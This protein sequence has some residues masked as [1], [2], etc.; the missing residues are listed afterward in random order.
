MPTHETTS[1][2]P[3]NAVAAIKET[4]RNIW[5]S[6]DCAAVANLTDSTQPDHLLRL[7]S[8]EPGQRIL[9]VA[10]GSGNVALRAAKAALRSS[11]ST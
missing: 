4:Q 2:E 5:T 9:D 10:T 3:D 6:G 11:V 1:V 7:V 8:I